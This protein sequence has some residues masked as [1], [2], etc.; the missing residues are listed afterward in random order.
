MHETLDPA[1]SKNAHAAEQRIGHVDLPATGALALLE[2]LPQGVIATDSQ[3][4]VVYMNSQAQQLVDYELGQ[5]AGQPIDFLRDA[6]LGVRVHCSPVH[7]EGSALRLYVVEPSTETGPSSSDLRDFLVDVAHELRTPVATI[8]AS[9][10]VLMDALASSLSDAP[11]LMLHNLEHEAERLA[12]LVDNL[13]DLHA[14]DA[15]RGRFHRMRCDLRSPAQRAVSSISPL[16]HRRE[17]VISLRLPPGPV[18]CWA[19]AA[20]LERAVLNLLSNA[21]KYGAENGQIAVRLESDATNARLAVEDDG[22]GIPESERERIFK[23]LYRGADAQARGI[24]GSGLGLPLCRAAVE[25]H[26]GRVFVATRSGGGSV[27]TIELPLGCGLESS[28]LPGR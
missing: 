3:D 9:A 6:G 20:L 7:V 12:S 21:H 24:H 23:R 13:L 17:Q 10:E 14:I 28:R 2:A 4:R 5:V 25:L 18:W 26:G 11:L 16:A 8:I 19:D 22:P 15:G 27:F 1:A